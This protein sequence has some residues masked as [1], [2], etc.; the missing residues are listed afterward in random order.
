[1]P[2]AK[3]ARAVSAHTEIGAEGLIDNAL[4]FGI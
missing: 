2:A 1:M 3:G 4:Q